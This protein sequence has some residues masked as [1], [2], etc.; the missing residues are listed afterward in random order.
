MPKVSKV[1][2]FRQTAAGAAAESSPATKSVG[3]DANDNDNDKQLSRGQ[4]KRQAKKDQYQRR[5]KLVLSSLQLQHEEDQKKRIDG[6]DAL[7][8][9]LLQ[10]TATDGD[11]PAVAPATDAPAHSMLKTNKNK[12][13]LTAREVTHFGL[14]LEHPS[15]QSNPFATIKEHLKNTLAL[16][17]Q[18][19]R[20][21]SALR[22]KQVAA[23]DEE[24][25]RIK[26][27][28]LQE[29]GGKQRKKFRGARM[30]RS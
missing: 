28:K 1:G 11:N 14:V 20:A 12:K 2:K 5:Q 18:D 24:K 19:V 13:E 27:E 8:K 3:D 23:K 16:S 10:S 30:S 4:R 22:D 17:A 9:A 6:L 21:Q 15:F 26:K 29:R 25:K 7:K